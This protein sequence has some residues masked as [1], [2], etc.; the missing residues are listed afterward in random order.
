MISYYHMHEDTSLSYGLFANSI[1]VILSTVL[2]A[3]RII[4]TEM[5]QF[6]DKQTIS[7]L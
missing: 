4:I 5:I 3:L 7:V 6:N 1:V 2:D